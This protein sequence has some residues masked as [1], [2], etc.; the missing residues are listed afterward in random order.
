MNWI[1]PAIIAPAIYA[2]VI[3]VDK[4]IL[5]KE[6][7]SLLSLP[8]FTSIAGI[9]FG[10]IFWSLNDFKLIPAEQFFLILLVGAITNWGNLLY[11][12][13]V[14]DE[15][16]S[17]IIILSQLH[18]AIVLLLAWIFLNEALAGSQILGFILILVPAIALSIDGDTDLIKSQ[19]KLSPAFWSIL[20]AGLL[21][22][23]AVIIFKP[24]SQDFS[25]IA[26]AAI[27]SWG[28]AFGGFI[29]YL[30]IPKMRRAFHKDIRRA[31]KALL[32]VLFN[33]SISIVAKL[34][35]FLAF[36]LGPVALVSVLGTTQIFIGIFLGLFL[37]K[38]IPSVFSETL[39]RSRLSSKVSWSLIMVIGFWLIQ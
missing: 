34:L 3:F 23:V 18:P 21:W 12:K 7:A 35:S 4:Y 25:L 8:L 17:L 28:I 37:T 19:R 14:S 20:G 2:L 36:S 5:E 30:A 13:A 9:L 33:E 6:I 32:V 1:L 26:L 29:L 11:F 39:D 31:N 15:D 38:Y 16:S 24:I 27:E 22:S 10:F